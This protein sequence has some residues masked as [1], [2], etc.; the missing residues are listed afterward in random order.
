VLD[1]DGPS[2]SFQVAERARPKTDLPFTSDGL[3]IALKA[4]ARR[5]PERSVLHYCNDRDGMAGAPRQF[6][7]RPGKRFGILSRLEPR[8][9][10]QKVLPWVVRMVWLSHLSALMMPR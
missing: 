6:R 4:K 3:P 5:I 7:E 2:S 1:P 9:I 8:R 10:A